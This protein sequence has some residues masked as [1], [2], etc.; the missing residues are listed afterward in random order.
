M[1]N[2]E[3]LNPTLSTRPTTSSM[4]FQHVRSQGVEEC[5]FRTIEKVET[6]RETDWYMKVTSHICDPRAEISGAPYKLLR[7]HYSFGEK[8]CMS[9]SNI[10]FM[11]CLLPLC[12]VEMSLWKMSSFWGHAHLFNSASVFDRRTTKV[13]IMELLYFHFKRD[14]DITKSVLKYVMLIIQ[15]SFALNVLRVTASLWQAGTVLRD[16]FHSAKLVHTQMKCPDAGKKKTFYAINA[17][18]L[19]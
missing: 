14:L 5:D 9:A 10:I 13:S 7:K 18:T 3:R 1:T 4:N 16:A 12:G 11:R 6:G 2:R 15:A 8:L 19:K 17:G